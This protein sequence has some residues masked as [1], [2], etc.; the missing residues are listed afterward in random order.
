K[1]AFMKRKIVQNHNKKI[2]IAVWENDKPRLVFLPGGSVSIDLY[3]P[4]LEKLSEYFSIV[5]LNWPGYGRSSGGVKV[6]VESYLE[7]IQLVVDHMKLDSF[8]LAGQ[9]L[10]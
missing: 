8:Y 6:S 10:G 5:A 4:F 1:Y 3:I 7:T 9:S 2:E